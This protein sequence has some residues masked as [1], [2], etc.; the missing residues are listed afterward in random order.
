[1]T[2]QRRRDRRAA[3]A[4]GEPS[5]LCGFKRGRN[6][7]GETRLLVF[8]N[9][10]RYFMYVAVAFIVLLYLDVIYSCTWPVL[11]D[12]GAV[13]GHEFNASLGSLVLFVT[14]TLLALYTFSCH[15]IRHLIGG[16]LNC[17][18]ET[19]TGNLRYRLWSIV[20][21][22]NKRHMLFAWLSLFMVGFADFYVWMVASGRFTDSPFFS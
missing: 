10:H 9:L 22:L 7:Q 1:M 19:A 18:P 4:V 15:S 14:T 21:I 17:Y 16:R 8:Q 2:R 20:S 12:S 13:T 3:C 11:D 6:Y 5:G